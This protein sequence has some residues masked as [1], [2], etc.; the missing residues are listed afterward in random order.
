[1]YA[2]WLR[3]AILFHSLSE[4]NC[5]NTKIIIKTSQTANFGFEFQPLSRAIIIIEI[6]LE[7]ALCNLCNEYSSEIRIA[8]FGPAVQSDLQVPRRLERL[9]TESI[10]GRSFHSS[11]SLKRTQFARSKRDGNRKSEFRNLGPSQRS[12]NFLA[13]PLCSPKPAVVLN[14]SADS[15]PKI[16]EKKTSGVRYGVERGGSDIISR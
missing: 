15:G 16:E 11:V 9:V 14:D 8:K 4:P 1:M 7:F 5:F 12:T 10:K 2:L 6:V 3:P 13:A